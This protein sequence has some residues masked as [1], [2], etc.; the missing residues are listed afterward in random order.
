[1]NYKDLKVIIILLKKRKRGS[2]EL[3]EK[4]NVITD[5]LFKLVKNPTGKNISQFIRSI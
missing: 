2:E 4:L 3:Q 1:M 5:A